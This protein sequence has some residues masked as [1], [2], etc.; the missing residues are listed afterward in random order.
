MVPKPCSFLSWVCWVIGC[1]TASP[2]AYCEGP[3]IW[4]C[5]K[6]GIKRGLFHFLKINDPRM[7]GTTEKKTWLLQGYL[8]SLLACQE[9]ANV[10]ASSFLSI[11]EVNKT[12]N[13]KF[14]YFSRLVLISFS[15]ALAV[16]SS[17]LPKGTVRFW[18]TEPLWLTSAPTAPR[19]IFIALNIRSSAADLNWLFCYSFNSS[20]FPH[21]L[22]TFPKWLQ[23]QS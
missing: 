9:V 18:R 5:V 15:F 7:P 10:R 4:E 13:I 8:S 2:G 21:L 22:T 16:C 3:W 20:P 23:M 11:Q 14:V 1:S 12:K 19:E 17:F 6:T